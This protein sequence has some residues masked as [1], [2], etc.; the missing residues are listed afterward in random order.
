M[1]NSFSSINKKEAGSKNDKQEINLVVPENMENFDDYIHL[2]NRKNK[3]DIILDDDGIVISERLI[4][5]K[6]LYK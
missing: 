2:Q 1:F 4:C 3:Q 5:I 6:I